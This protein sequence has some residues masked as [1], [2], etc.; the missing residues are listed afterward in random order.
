MYIIRISM[1]ISFVRFHV[2]KYEKPP[3]KNLTIMIEA[4]DR[5]LTEKIFVSNLL[6]IICNILYCKLISYIHNI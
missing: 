6:N 1:G 3:F 2:N 5:Y 4:I